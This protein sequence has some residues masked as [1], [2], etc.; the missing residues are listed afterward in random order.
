MRSLRLVPV[1]T[2][3][4]L[5][6][7][8]GVS[9]SGS[10]GTGHAPL[11]S[12]GWSVTT[13]FPSPDG[14]LLSFIGTP[15]S[16]D[17]TRPR[18]VLAGD[19]PVELSP[20]V[21]V[22]RSAAWMPDSKSLLLAYADELGG[23][24]ATRFAVVGID[25]TVLREVPAQ[26]EIN[27]S[28]GLAVSPDGST[29]VLPANELGPYDTVGELWKLDLKTGQAR[30]IDFRG[31]SPGVQENPSYASAEVVVFGAGELSWEVGG[32]NGWIANLN[33]V[34]GAVDRLTDAS[35][36]ALTPSVSP[37]G[38]FVVYDAFPGN[39][40]SKRGLWYVAR[41][42]TTQPTELIASLDGRAPILEPGGRTVLVVDAGLPGDRSQIRRLDVPEDAPWLLG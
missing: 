3:L 29:A 30:V 31:H 20:G 42:G 8:C 36:T 17:I 1:I 35:Q 40:R 14:R 2:L 37:D 38:A 33:T 41:D 22:A 18:L 6:A 28:Y 39:Q 24:H 34:T 16:G 5:V 4:L 12:Q 11:G 9:D 25:G 32:P 10:N 23:E 7:S 13:V 27:A 19:D 21:T 26:V 15:T